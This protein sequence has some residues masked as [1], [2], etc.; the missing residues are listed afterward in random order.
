MIC[1]VCYMI[2][3]DM[4]CLLVCVDVLVTLCCAFCVLDVGV[5]GLCWFCVVVLCRCGCWLLWWCVYSSVVWFYVFMLCL[6]LFGALGVVC[7]VV[8]LRLRCAVC[9]MLRVL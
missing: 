3:Y 2:R 7:C 8:A 5:R 6:F 9:V 1:D 4:L